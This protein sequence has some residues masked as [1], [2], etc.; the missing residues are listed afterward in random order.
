VLHCSCCSFLFSVFM[1]IYYSC[2]FLLTM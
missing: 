1:N 2:L